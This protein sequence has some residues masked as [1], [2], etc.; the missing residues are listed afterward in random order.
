MIS[1]FDDK[2]FNFI[3]LI[4]AVTIVVAPAAATE[5]VL[6]SIFLAV[7]RT[8]HGESFIVVYKVVVAALLKNAYS[9][10]SAASP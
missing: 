8:P 4:A 10:F 1:T 5:K 2:T 9:I 7:A 3:S 6:S